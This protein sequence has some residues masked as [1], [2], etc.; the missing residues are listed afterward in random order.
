MCIEL[1]KLLPLLLQKVMK[2]LDRLLSKYN[3]ATIVP[4]PLATLQRI[5]VPLKLRSTAQS[6]RHI[7]PLLL[8]SI[9]RHPRGVIIGDLTAYPEGSAEEQLVPPTLLPLTNTVLFNLLSPC[10]RA[11]LHKWIPRQASPPPMTI[12]NL[13]LLLEFPLISATITDIKLHL[14]KQPPALPFA[15]LTSLSLRHPGA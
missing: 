10:Y 8:K 2:A 11:G 1:P 9:A 15:C 14:P 4:L 12:T 3:F 7:P 6:Y 13:G 5:P